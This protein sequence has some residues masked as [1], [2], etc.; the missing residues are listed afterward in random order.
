MNKSTTKPETD[1]GMLVPLDAVVRLIR[2]RA[3]QFAS[4]RD[5]AIHEKEW[6]RA[7]TLD[8]R[9]CALLNLIEDVGHINTKDT[10]TLST[11][12]AKYKDLIRRLGCCSHDG[13]VKEIAALRQHSGLDDAPQPAA[14]APVRS[15]PLFGAWL[16]IESA[17]RDGTEILGWRKDCGILMVRWDA[18]ENFMTDRE[19]EEIGESASVYDWLYADFVEGGRLEGQEAPT[20]WMPLPQEPNKGSSVPPPVAGGG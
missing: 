6:S 16:P 12:E 15:E 11:W 20:H 7:A 5:D 4:M 10:A 1:T 17:P 18:P 14:L 3:D 2:K 13:A 9:V 8:A 19:C